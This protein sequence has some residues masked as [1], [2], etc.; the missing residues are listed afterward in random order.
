VSYKYA[1]GIDP[2]SFV[3]P[4][5]RGWLYIVTFTNRSAN[6]EGIDLLEN[7]QLSFEIDFS[8]SELDHP[9]KGNDPLVAL[10][11]GIIIQSQLEA[12]GELPIYY[13]VCEIN[14]QKQ[15]GR[16]HLFTKW[17]ESGGPAGW[18]LVNFEMEDSQE[19]GLLYYAGLLV[20]VEHPNCALIPDVF[21]QF[22][23][24]DVTSGKFIRRR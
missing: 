15:A 22:L 14:D 17:F 9:L 18:D 8:R 21:A 6:F 20:H 5:D 11:L 7:N 23:E 24:Q 3:F 16:A 13:F 2:L 10:T 12:M 19:N 1:P 4:T